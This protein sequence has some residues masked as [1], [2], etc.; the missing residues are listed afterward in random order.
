MDKNK[1]KEGKKDKKQA[2]EDEYKLEVDEAQFIKILTKDLNDD[3]K[4]L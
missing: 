1:E 2:Q 4:K 3:K